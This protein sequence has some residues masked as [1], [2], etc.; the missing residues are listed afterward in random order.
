M[1]EVTK[2]QLADTYGVSKQTVTNYIDRLALQDHVFRRGQ[3]DVLDE[4][5]VQVLS[6]ALGKSTVKQ[7]VAFVDETPKQPQDAVLEALNSQIADLKQDK[8]QLNEQV[9]ELR[10]ELIN[11]RAE[12]QSSHDAMVA[13][14]KRASNAEGRIQSLSEHLVTIADLG[15]FARAKAAKQLPKR[16]GDGKGGAG[17]NG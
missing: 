15:F 16:L 14:E 9:K 6:N 4:H 3:T 13:A 1:A 2:R 7:P 10:R 8:E 5:A 17:G 11:L 12:A